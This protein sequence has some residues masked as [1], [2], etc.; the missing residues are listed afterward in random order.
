MG[1][2]LDKCYEHHH[3]SS[4][5]TPS[6][7]W[8]HSQRPGNEGDHK[9]N[10]DTTHPPHTHT[11]LSP[12]S[13][14]GFSAVGVNIFTSWSRPLVAR[15]GVWGWG[16]R[17]LTCD[18]IWKDIEMVCRY[19][20]ITTV[21]TLSDPLYYTLNINTGH[22]ITAHPRSHDLHTTPS[23]SP[24]RNCTTSS[25]SLSQRKTWPQSLPLTTYSLLRP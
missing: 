16:S 4:H 5:N 14:E 7:N 12:S 8:P 22:T 17:Q 24:F 18:G 13:V 15:T 23:W 2:L 20:P 10:T 9:H 19:I 11:S 1:P 6:I 3:T 25:V 21:T